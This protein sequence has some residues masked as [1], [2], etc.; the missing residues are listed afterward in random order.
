MT[1]RLLAGCLLAALLAGALLAACGNGDD[2]RQTRVCHACDPD[3]ARGCF[4]ECRELC[5]PGDPDCDSRCASQCDECRRD[6]VCLECRGDCTGTL[7]RCAPQNEVV[8]CEDGT[9]GGMTPT[10]PT[11]VATAQL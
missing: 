8:S 5:V 3:V 6:L 11:P 1:G 9:F 2:D 10:A 7:R 4:N